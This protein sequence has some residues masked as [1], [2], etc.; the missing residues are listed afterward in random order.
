M[1]SSISRSPETSAMPPVGPVRSGKAHPTPTK[2][3]AIGVS[4]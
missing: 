2:S 3:W 4:S 1:L